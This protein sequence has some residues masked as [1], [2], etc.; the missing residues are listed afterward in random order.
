MY[1]LSGCSGE[2][3]LQQLQ[4]LL[5]QEVGPVPETTSTGETYWTLSVYTVLLVPERETRLSKT[6]NE[7]IAVIFT[8]HVAL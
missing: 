2:Q 8:L 1:S 5:H 7:L 6:Y 3:S 4:R